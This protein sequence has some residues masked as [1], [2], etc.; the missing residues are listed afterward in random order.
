[1]SSEKGTAD[2]T[3]VNS[4]TTVIGGAASG[5]TSESKGSRLFVT[6]AL[7]K[8][9]TLY[10]YSGKVTMDSAGGE[11]TTLKTT[12]TSVGVKHSF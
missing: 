4:G 10:G 9:T 12:T 2:G 8:R 7:S 3:G 11:A 1:V 6:Y 5:D